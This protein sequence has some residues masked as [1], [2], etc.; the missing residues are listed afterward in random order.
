MGQMCRIHAQC[1]LE[2]ENRAGSTICGEK[3]DNSL[4]VLHPDAYC[5]ASGADVVKKSFST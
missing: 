3:G 1:I 4:V 5:C 2:G